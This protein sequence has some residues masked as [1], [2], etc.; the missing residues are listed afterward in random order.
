MR[1]KDDTGKLRD[2]WRVADSKA[3]A[4]KKLKELLKEVEGKTAKEIDAVNLTLSDLAEYYIKNYLHEAVYVGDKKVSGVRGVT[5][6]LCAVKPLITH[7][8]NRKIKALTYG[9][10]RTYKQV[11]LTT[12]TK[13]GKQRAIATVNKEL[14]KLK[15]MFNIAVREQWLSRN[16]FENGESLIGQEDHR[17]RILSLDEEKRLIGAIESNLKRSHIKGIVL[18]GL[19]CALRRGEIFTLR[20]FDVDFVRRTLTVRAFNAKTARKRTVA[21]GRLCFRSG[22]DCH[23]EFER[24]SNLRRTPAGIAKRRQRILFQ[25]TCQRKS[26]EIISRNVL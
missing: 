24:V 5:E 6:A 16:P 4:N 3:D 15:R 9:D 13:H 21:M 1:F 14:N 10:I 17:T 23:N 11:R 8:G 12:P 22:Q 20:W 19:D 7:F 26:A 25:P 2:L 18:I